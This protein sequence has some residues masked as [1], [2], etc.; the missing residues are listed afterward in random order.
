MAVPVLFWAGGCGEPDYRAADIQLDLTGDPPNGAASLRI[1]VDGVGQRVLGYRLAGSYSYPGL[2]ADEPL[3]VRV[4][5]L[6]DQ[7]EVLAQG[8][9]LSLAGYTE[10]VLL[11]CVQ[12]EACEASG[13][14]A[15]PDGA[16]WLLAVRLLD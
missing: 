8:Q 6:D 7:G 10:E 2:P 13:S 4:D 1:C 12:C 11:E 9:A 3:D 16:S 14:A 5:V 15:D